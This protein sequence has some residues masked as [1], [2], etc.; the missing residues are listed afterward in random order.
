MSFFD[1]LRAVFGWWC[2]A[3]AVLVLAVAL[4]VQVGGLF[5]L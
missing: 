5:F 2:A 1:E 4:G 3:L